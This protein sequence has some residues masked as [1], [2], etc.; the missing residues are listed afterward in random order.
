LQ[1]EPS[2]CARQGIEFRGFPIADRGVP[3]SAGAFAAFVQALIADMDAGRSVAVHCRAGIG[4]SSLV[5]ACVL[6]W[7]GCSV[8]EA[9]DRIA[10]ARGC[11]VPDTPEQRAWV[12]RFMREWRGEAR[13]APC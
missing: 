13:D 10:K 6:A 7:K 4:R 1:A 5:A 9:F 12:A 11:P 2:E 8:D 3:E